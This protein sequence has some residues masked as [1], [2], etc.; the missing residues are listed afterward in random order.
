MKPLQLI[1]VFNDR[2]ALAFTSAPRHVGA[3]GWS[4]TAIL[5]CALQ[6][7]RGVE[8]AELE[9]EKLRKRLCTGVI[10][11]E[12]TP[13]EVIKSGQRSFYELILDPELSPNIAFVEENEDEA[14]NFA[15]WHTG[16]VSVEALRVYGVST[17]LQI[18]IEQHIETT[19][20]IAEQ[21]AKKRMGGIQ[22]PGRD[23]GVPP[24]IRLP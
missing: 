20:A 22:I 6:L 4:R 24:N 8:L 19:M 1:L 9:G 12:E 15:V 18:L 13:P 2:G 11:P 16:R 5:S 3:E 17:L 14:Y 21:A 10:L 7:A 23:G